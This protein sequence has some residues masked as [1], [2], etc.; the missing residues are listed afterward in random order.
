MDPVSL[1]VGALAAGAT[2]GLTEVSGS[3]VRDAYDRLRE[4]VRRRFVGNKPAEVALQE[5]ADDAETWEPPLRKYLQALDV[6]ADG[7]LMETATRLMALIDAR[8]TQAG[9]YDVQIHDSTNVQVGD[10]NIMLNQ[11]PG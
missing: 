5:H 6:G 9:K 8:G 4:A 7:E 11:S 2:T 10:G 3:A 1:I